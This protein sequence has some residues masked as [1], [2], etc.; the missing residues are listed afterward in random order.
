MMKTRQVT[1]QIPARLRLQIC[2]LERTLDKYWMSQ[3]II[4][5][6]AESCSLPIYQLYYLVHASSKV[7][8]VL[9]LR[10]V[11]DQWV[12]AKD[13]LETDT[14]SCLLACAPRRHPGNSHAYHSFSVFSDKGKEMWPILLLGTQVL[15]NF[16]HV[17]TASP[18]ETI[19]G[20]HM[21]KT[22]VLRKPHSHPL[23]LALIFFPLILLTSAQVQSPGFCA[24]LLLLK[25][26]L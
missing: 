15:N 2:Y 5:P 26:S 3:S 17:L 14:S 7:T 13:L 4:K 20:G 18:R 12:L 10:W 8:K 21:N 23:N 22:L 25:I 19:P 1:K 11:H 9:A 6:P 24:A 16:V